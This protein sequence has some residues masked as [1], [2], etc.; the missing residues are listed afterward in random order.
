M[1]AKKRKNFFYLKTTT[2]NSAL[3]FSFCVRAYCIRIVERLTTLFWGEM[4]GN[5]LHMVGGRVRIFIKTKLGFIF[6]PAGL[7]KCSV[8]LCVIFSSFSLL[9]YHYK[10][11]G[12]FGFG[13]PQERHFLLYFFPQTHSPHFTFPL[14]SFFCAPLF[15]YTVYIGENMFHFF[16]FHMYNTFSVLL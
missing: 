12:F 11:L 7:F 2:R 15:K 4:M 1:F 3:F 10:T 9:R 14:S 5:S 8:V 13:S 6:G 16:F